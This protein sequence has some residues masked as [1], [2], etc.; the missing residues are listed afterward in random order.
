MGDKVLVVGSGGREHALVWK[1]KQSPLVDQV[2]YAP[3][4]A[5]TENNVPIEATNVGALTRFAKREDI[6]LTVVGPEK[7]LVEGIVDEFTK[8]GLLIYGPS[9]EAAKIE[10]SKAFADKFNEEH[11]IPQAANFA[12]FHEEEQAKEYV[13]ENFSEKQNLVV[14]ADGLAAGKGSIVCNSRKEA[15]D[16]IEWIM[17]PDFAKKY[18]DSGEKLVI[19]D[20]LLGEEASVQAIVDTSGE[21]RMLDSAQDHKPIGEGGIGPNTGGMGS[22]SPYKRIRGELREKIRRSIIDK[23]VTGMKKRGDPFSGTLYAGLMIDEDENPYVLEFN[24]RFGD[25]ELQP[26]VV[27]MK[28]DLYKYLKKAAQNRLDEMGEVS[29]TPHSASCVTMASGGYP[30]N[31]TKGYPIKGFE[32]VNEISNVHVFHA[33]TKRTNDDIVTDGGRVLGVTALG[34]SLKEAQTLA[35]ASARCITFT[36]HYWRRDIGDKAMKYEE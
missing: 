2:F 24:V 26:I 34:S 23:A 17:G 33:G 12:V 28:S 25:P 18:G 32:T 6:D 13:K 30:K 4:N 11:G 20:R 22:I 8:Q 15:F 36:N 19:E 16:A 21:I 7:P 5:G 10:G 14:K 9:K 27:R 3:G 1:L 35:N 29:F 31:Y